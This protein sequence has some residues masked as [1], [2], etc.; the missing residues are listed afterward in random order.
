MKNHKACML[1]RVQAGNRFGT[2]IQGS[3]QV[4]KCKVTDILYSGICCLLIFPNVIVIRLFVYKIS[5]T[6]IYYTI[7]YAGLIKF[8]NVIVPRV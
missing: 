2:D 1:P 3:N 5:A 7:E 4:S 6:K 8:P